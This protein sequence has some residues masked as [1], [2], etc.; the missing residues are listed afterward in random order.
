[1]PKLTVI[2]YTRSQ[3]WGYGHHPLEK[4][5]KFMALFVSSE[6]MRVSISP[7]SSPSR[8]KPISR[9]RK[10]S[11]ALERAMSKK[12]ACW[13][14]KRLE[15][16]SQLAALRRRRCRTELTRQVE[17]LETSST[18]ERYFPQVGGTVYARERKRKAPGSKDARK[19]QKEK[20]KFSLFRKV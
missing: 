16:E 12:N 13:S 8:R 14:S 9:V 6:M 5:L 1:M 2:C 17:K 7:S 18:M 20:P 3:P 11:A 15:L 19:A 4:S 10:N